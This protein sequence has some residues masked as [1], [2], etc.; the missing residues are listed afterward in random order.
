MR[1]V[2]SCGQHVYDQSSNVDPRRVGSR[3]YPHPTSFAPRPRQL[4]S[5]AEHALAVDSR[6]LPLRVADVAH[7]PAAARA[8]RVERAHAVARAR[9]ERGVLVGE[10]AIVLLGRSVRLG[11][12]RPRQR[13]DLVVVVL[14]LEIEDR[15]AGV[16]VRGR[17]EVTLF[18]V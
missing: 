9:R 2:D 8:R 14:A 10:R 18:A 4:T 6:L 17:L 7:P 15:V 3:L 5:F 16:V 12:R 13:A 1:E 11:R